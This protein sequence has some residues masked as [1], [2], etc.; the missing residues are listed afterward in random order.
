VLTCECTYFEIRNIMR[1]LLTLMLILLLYSCGENQVESDTTPFE[2]RDISVEEKMQLALSETYLAK[3][4]LPDSTLHYLTD[5]YSSRDFKPKW[6]NDSTLTET[7]EKLMDAFQNS[8][9]I[10]IPIG[11]IT[12][13]KSDNYIQDEIRITLSL[14]QVIHDLK[15]GLINYTDKSSNP[16]RYIQAAELDDLMTFEKNKDIRIQFLKYG[17]KDSTYEVLG[18]GLIDLLDNFPLDTSTFDI[19]SIKFDTLTATSKS[20]KALIS[21]G[22]LAESSVDS[23]NFMEALAHFQIDNGLKPDGVIGKYTSIAL[24]ESTQHKVERILLAMD[25]IRTRTERPNKYIW[26]NIPEYKLRF[27]IN[28]SLKSEHN[29]VTGTTANQT[30]ELVSKLR[31]IVVYPFWNVPYSISSKEILPSVKRDTGYLAKHNYKLLK[32]GQE[33]DP[34]SVEWSSIRQNAFPFKIRQEPGRGN[35]L[36]LIKFVF[37]NAYSVYFHDTPSKSL[38]NV[39]VRAYSH[40][41]MRTQYPVTL[42]KAILKRDKLGRRL[43]RTIPDS[44][45]TLL[46]RKENYNIKVLD[47]VPIFIEYQTVTRVDTKMITYID[48][49]G[50]DEQYL[51][52]LRE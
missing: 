20:Q 42:A 16:V 11:R 45:D 5:Y 40:G 28:D 22:Y 10:G 6:I 51:K 24:N 49:Y 50:R 43:N 46:G 2:F 23:T 9:S 26:I 7:G 38:F 37:N 33:V 3:L 21:K 27:Y 39:D 17:P 14:S 12:E 30:P 19:E 32:D 13:I 15:T 34:H 35:A 36:G 8:Y 25:K 48:I 41:C 47:P 4:G 52:I 1:P 18:A 29:I 44:L 31:K